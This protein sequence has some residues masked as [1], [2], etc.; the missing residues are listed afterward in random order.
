MTRSRYHHGGCRQQQHP[1]GHPGALLL[2]A[3]LVGTAVSRY[4]RPPRQELLIVHPQHG[5]PAPTY[6][7][8]AGASYMYVGRPNQRLRQIGNASHLVPHGPPD[9]RLAWHCEVCFVAF[10]LL[11]RRHHCRNC[12]RSVC[13]R[14]AE[15]R[16]PLPHWGYLNY[17][18]VCDRCHGVVMACYRAGKPYSPSMLAMPAA[19]D[20]TAANGSWG[21]VDR[22]FLLASACGEVPRGDIISHGTSVTAEA[23]ASGPP[24]ARAYALSETPSGLDVAET[25]V[26]WATPCVQYQLHPQEM[27]WQE[28]CPDRPRALEGLVTPSAPPLSEDYR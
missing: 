20:S 25:P 8:N 17:V 15:K 14:H 27:P 18:R 16:V 9:W 12:G 19:R 7:Q 11:T 10:G 22:D 21:H 24:L 28:Q 1:Q 3:A 13:S 6:I 23:V 26:A 5:N 2:G 4:I